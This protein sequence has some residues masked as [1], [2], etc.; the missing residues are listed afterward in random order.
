MHSTLYLSLLALLSVAVQANAATITVPTQQASIQ[1]AVN[2][3]AAG[4]TIVVKP[5]TYEENVTIPTGL[6]GLTVK[7]VG[8]AGKVILDCRPSGATDTGGGF[9]VSSSNVTI[10]GFVIRHAKGGSSATGVFTPIPVSGLTLRKLVIEH[11]DGAAIQ[12][13]GADATIDSCVAI[14]C[15]GGIRIAGSGG[16]ITK[17]TVR[18]DGERGIDINGDDG[19]VS[20]C[21]VVTIED[22][23]GIS[24]NGL[25]GVIEKN[26]VDGADAAAILISGNNP[27]VRGNK[28]LRQC[29]DDCGIE[30]SGASVGVIE[31]NLVRNTYEDGI[32]IQAT[33]SGLTIS[34]NTIIGCGT[35]DEPGIQLD[36]NNCVVANN[37]IKGAYADG[38][39]VGGD[40]NSLVDNTIVDCFEDGIDIRIGAD[41]TTVSGNKCLK[42]RGEGFENNG[43]NTTLT[44]NTMKNNRIDFADDGTFATTPS[45]NSFTTG[46]VGTAPEID[47]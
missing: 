41:G 9:L 40:G 19:T 23:S 11:A 34:K 1:A 18:Q 3:A 47:D 30:V 6:D 10:Q 2:A 15:D 22:G 33:A 42:N 8:G 27:T 35:E 20:K 37:V 32:E 38:I 14:G 21:V 12:V 36:G 44:G 46:G 25:N 16:L 43:A 26:V 5:G 28:I 29:D 45:G 17:C 31:K 24:I 7:A 4:D 13:A 39:N